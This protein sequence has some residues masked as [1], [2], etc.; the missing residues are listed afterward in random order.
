MFFPG[1]KTTGRRSCPVR[2]GSIARP[3]AAHIAGLL[4]ATLGASPAAHGAELI[5]SQIWQAHFEAWVERALVRDE[6]DEAARH[7]PELDPGSTLRVLNELVK[8]RLDGHP[9]GLALP[10]E[11]IAKIRA[12]GI[13]GPVRQAALHYAR[14][15]IEKAREILDAPELESDADAAHLQA[16]IH[17]A[18]TENEEPYS[19]YHRLEAIADYR[20][21]LSLSEESAQ[22][23]RAR[24]RIGQILAELRFF[25]E[26]RATFRPL[27]ERELREPYDLAAQ[28]SYTETTYLARDPRRTLVSLGELD[29][30]TLS[31]ALRHWAIRRTGDSFYRLGN[32]RAAVRAYTRLIEEASDPAQIDPITRLRLTMALLELGKPSEAQLELAHVLG[33]T[34][35]PEELTALAGLLLARALRETEAYANAADVAAEVARSRGPSSESALAWVELLESRGRVGE[36]VL[37]LSDE[38]DDLAQR[39]DEAPAY[40]LL[41]YRL[42]QQPG[43][44]ETPAELRTLL[45][46]LLPKLADGPVR[47][48]AR[49]DLTARLQ[50]HLRSVQLGEEE[51]DPQ[52]L[53]DVAEYLHPSH[54]DQ[55]ALLL[56][57]E[58]FYRSGDWESCM[59]WGRTLHRSDVR[60]IR[61]GLGAW[62]DLQCRRAK[63][64]SLVSSRNL[65]LLADGGRTGS[66][67]LALAAVAAEEALRAGDPQEAREIYD[68]ALHSVADPRLLGPVLLRA[69]EL[70][71]AEGRLRVGARKLLRGLALTDED[72]VVHD[73]FRKAGLVALGRVTATEKL[74]KDRELTSVLERE[75]ERAESW[76]A[77]VYAYLGF[78]AGRTGAPHGGDVFSRAA[79]EVRRVAEL[80]SRVEKIVGREALETART[81]LRSR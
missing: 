27:L 48:L 7:A 43:I 46:Q 20:Y 24:V 14:G 16:Q 36:P 77:P 45:G 72:D 40:D 70:D 23:D 61:K 4:L 28:V 75:R 26:A 34:D 78:R 32:A 56:G 50:A 15:D 37:E 63:Q 25:P 42:L 3:F 60:P 10:S 8:A 58:S 18:Q 80:R 29:L 57:L 2:R 67:A 79:L 31:P 65:I 81:E 11:V 17:D 21:A 53:K 55:D 19:P 66:F 54:V 64:P 74:R 13:S 69:A 44:A 35:A 62:R 47:R 68:A 71:L 9:E 5:D 59:R 6:L 51:L 38:V 39:T 1:E 76:W 22:E 41:A 12:P 49:D 33:D 52:V 30:E 73:P